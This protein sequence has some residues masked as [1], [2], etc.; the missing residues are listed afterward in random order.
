LAFSAT[1]GAGRALTLQLG[2]ARQQRTAFERASAP[3]DAVVEERF[4]LSAMLGEASQLT[5]VHDWS[6][7]GQFGLASDHQSAASGLVTGGVFASPYLALADTGDGLALAQQLGDRWSLRFGLARAD[8]GEQD[9]YGSGDNTVMLG[10]LV[11]AVSEHLRLSLQLGR[12]EEQGRVLDASGGGALGLPEGSGT[13]F[14]G[15]AT[16]AELFAGLELFGQGNL[17]LTT[18]DGAGQGL[19]EDLST[20]YSS[21][22][23][24]GLARRDLG[25]AGD[26]LT[27]AISQPLRIEAG[28]AAIDRPLGR[29]LDGRIVRRRDRIDL[30]PEGRELDLELGYRVGL[31]GVGE[32]SLNWLSRLQPN[33]DTEARP[34][35]AV[36]VKLRR[37][38]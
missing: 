9:S 29:T 12:L 28:Q 21:S 10:E 14:L 31:A 4:A 36:A 35:H 1:L 13:T 5:V 7:Q 18:P 23:G 32:L 11:G 27:V 33:H 8:R 34:D 17:G 2:N 37:R 15:L 20:L 3:A 6:L 25:I 38:F 24:F 22:F 19:L 16:R 26:R 30:A